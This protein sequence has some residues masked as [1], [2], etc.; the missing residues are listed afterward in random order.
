MISPSPRNATARSHELARVRGL[1]EPAGRALLALCELAANIAKTPIAAISLS[2]GRERRFV[3]AV[4]LDARSWARA[5]PFLTDGLAGDQPFVITDTAADPRFRESAWVNGAPGVRFYAGLP[6]ETAPGSPIGTL[7]VMDHRPRRLPAD[8][9]TLLRQAATAASG[10]LATQQIQ[11]GPAKP[12]SPLGSQRDAADAVLPAQDRDPA[13]H[14]AQAL[15]KPSLRE[16]RAQIRRAIGNGEFVPFYQSKVELKWGRIIGFEVLARWQHPIRGLL[17]PH[18]FQP[19]ISDRTITPMLTRAILNA[20]LRDSASW[21][22]SGLSPGRL[23]INVSSADLMSKSFAAEFIQTLER[24]SFAASDLVIEVTEGI[25]MGEPDGQIHKTLSA[26]RGHG[27]RVTLDDFGTGF[28]GLQHLRNWPIDGLKLDR[29]FVRNCLTNKEDQIIIRSIVQMCRDLELEVV[30]EGIE[31][32]AQYLFLSNIGCDFGQ[33]FYFSKPV[34]ADDVPKL[35]RGASASPAG[36]MPRPV[37][38]T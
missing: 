5:A 19:A 16:T 32:N 24:Y 33:G 10:I 13:I 27:V 36:N 35:L 8:A 34:P 38:I 26:L 31:D 21:R 25:A 17:A 7:S 4:G 11:I 29:G 3:A 23:A 6:L 37:N 14:T 9:I 30:A 1:S 20:A 18:D 22:A 12:A 15:S 2:T 28:A